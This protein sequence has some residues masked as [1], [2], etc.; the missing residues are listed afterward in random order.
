[1]ESNREEILRI[2]MFLY[3]EQSKK[4]NVEN[5]CIKCGETSIMIDKNITFGNQS[6]G[7]SRKKQSEPLLT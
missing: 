7:K 3:W 4:S 6:S 1:M 5:T 2:T